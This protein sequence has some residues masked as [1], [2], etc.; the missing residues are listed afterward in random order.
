MGYDIGGDIVR[1]RIWNVSALLR[2][3]QYIDLSMGIGLVVIGPIEIYCSLG[4]GSRRDV[5]VG[6]IKSKIRIV[7]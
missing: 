5:D 7:C 1:T 6:W 4:L 3:R 2:R